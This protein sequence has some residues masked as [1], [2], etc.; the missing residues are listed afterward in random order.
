MRLR[1]ILTGVIAG[2]L[3][4]ASCGN[5][6][7]VPPQE[8]EGTWK[9][10]AT[11]MTNPDMSCT[12]TLTFN[13]VADTRGGRIDIDAVFTISRKVEQAPKDSVTAT[14]SGTAKA[15]GTWVIEDGDDMKLILTLSDTKVEVDTASLNLTYS[16]PE[17]DTNHSALISR[18]SIAETISEAVKPMVTEKIQSITEFDDVSV[19]DNIMTLEIDHNMITFT[20]Q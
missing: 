2:V 4:L 6:S 10:E 3:G 14:I 5:G 1:L 17:K 8:M 19:A 13:R 18:Q 7:S 11:E 9:G 16:H 20:K 15:S 12:P